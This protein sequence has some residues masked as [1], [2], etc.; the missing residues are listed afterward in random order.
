MTDVVNQPWVAPPAS[1]RPST[2]VVGNDGVDDSLVGTAGNDALSGL[3]GADTMSGGLGDDTYYIDN[4]GDLIDED[5]DGGIDTLISYLPTIRLPDRVENLTLAGSIEKSGYGNALANIIRGTA[6]NNHLDG[7]AGNDLLYG[8]GGNDV[9]VIRAGNGSDAIGDFRA[10]HTT[11]S[12]VSLV[13]Y[14][15]TSFDQIRAAMVQDGTT[16]ILNLGNGETLRFL[17]QNV[18]NFSA[19]DFATGL[20]TSKWRLTFNDDFDTFDRFDGVDGTW[21]TKHQWDG[22]A[23]YTNPSKAERQIYVDSDY[24]GVR[25]NQAPDSIGLNPFTIDDGVLEIK[26]AATPTELNQWT[27]WRPYYSG[28]I[29]SFSSFQQTY[30]YFEIRAKL[31]SGQAL[32]PAFWMLPADLGP[33][34]EIDVFEALGQNPF[35]ALMT[36]H[37]G[38]TGVRT[39]EGY[40]LLTPDLTAG[41]HDFGMDWGP[42]HLTWYLDGVAVGTAKT[43]DDMKN[44]PMYMIA[45]LAVGGN[46]GG[47]PSGNTLTGDPTYYIDRIR[48]FATQNTVSLPDP[49]TRIGN[50]G[51]DYFQGTAYADSLAG[52]EQNDQLYGAAGNDT[53]DG[54]EGD[55]TLGGGQGDDTIIGGNGIDVALY[56]GDLSR[57]IVV[58]DLDADTY[59]AIDTGTQG[60]QGTDRLSGV[61]TLRFRS[62]D[63]VTGVQ[64]SAVD[65]A[66]ADATRVSLRGNLA[67]GRDIVLDDAALLLPS[68]ATDQPDTV[69]YGGT[70]PLVLAD[71]FENAAVRGAGAG[72]LVGNASANILI[73]NASDD[74]LAGGGGDDVLR[75]LGGSDRLDGGA[76]LDVAEYVGPASQFVVLRDLDAPGRFRVVDLLAAD[77][78]GDRL[79]DI[80]RLRFRQFDEVTGEIASTVEMPIAEAV[81]AS[82][83]RNAAGGRDLFTA[84]ATSVTPLL[85][86]AGVDTVRFGGSSLILPA[87][88]ENAVATG[89]GPVS[90]T[91]NAAANIL[92]GGAGTDTLAGEGGDDILDP[93][94]ATG[95]VDGGAGTDTVVLHGPA[96]RYVFVAVPFVPGAARVYDLAAGLN[97]YLTL[98]NVEKVAFT[99]GLLAP[100]GLP[101]EAVLP[102]G[103]TAD[104][105]LSAALPL[106]SA[107][108]ITASPSADGGLTIP[109]ADATLIPLAP[110]SEGIDTVIF[111]GRGAAVLSDGLEN[112]VSTGLFETTLTGNAAANVLTGGR[113]GTTFSGLAGN[114]TFV[115]TALRPLDT[116]DYSLDAAAGGTA[117]VTVDLQQGRAVDGF[118]DRDT[119]RAITN[120]VGTEA[121]DLILGSE[122]GNILRGL[123]GDDSLVGGGGADRLDGGAGNDTLDGGAGADLL[124]GGDGIN[125]ADYGSSASGLVADLSNPDNNTGDAAGDRY[126]RI[127]GLHGS[128]FADGLTGSSLGDVVRGR[129]GDDTLDG[130]AGNDTL[131]GDDGDDLLLGGTG[132]DHLF[133]GLGIDR[134][135]GGVGY[136]QLAGGAG[137][138]TFVI[139]AAQGSGSADTIADFVSGEDR[140]EVQLSGVVD[141]S[142]L[143]SVRFASVAA[144]PP[145]VAEPT[146]FYETGSGR[147]MWEGSPDPSSRV[148]LA[149]L[150]GRPSL[151]A[152]DLVIV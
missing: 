28:M 116:V 101:A 39:K 35:N 92:V 121:G 80:E 68:F 44:R 18:Q 41:Y 111:S 126:S 123:G 151:S 22:L 32:W 19:D 86:T 137:S 3:S 133:G 104:E 7:G 25:F 31:P 106:A 124:M 13:G 20:D 53:L 60:N 85:A 16:A 90:L 11:S 149:T 112:L 55:D 122:T 120:A 8:G 14:D 49:L 70:A 152:D 135:I 107:N 150:S 62:H 33:I 117:G 84:S 71:A 130:L 109:L 91:G 81:T 114:D 146:L 46:W 136:D 36:A 72:N 142:R 127:Y 52:L 103:S 54:G 5:E 76:G 10:G 57:L 113:G 30:G 139:S 97:A 45:N 105:I 21:V 34:T 40:S 64:T 95:T 67:G 15:F 128:S 119:L 12:I 50:S 131:H 144:L 47:A 2:S 102:D 82:F 132:N 118:G 83:R 94:S 110:V 59:A 147:L 9:F 134:L 48:A 29:S 148:L 99:A 129:S 88:Y 108:T 89:T 145:S 66:I 69:V 100:G 77:Q 43:P 65:V 96:S 115:G 78:E 138:D 141:P 17:N 143:A 75:G 125:T 4:P 37:S 26:A 27:S 38:T 61:E 140:L 73:G 63:A 56:N 23:G 79:Q 98:R 1:K 6:V 24:K 74:T 93:L 51:L 58:H 42:D 87:G